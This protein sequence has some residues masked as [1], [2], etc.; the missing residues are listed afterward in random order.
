MMHQNGCDGKFGFDVMSSYPPAGQ[1]FAFRHA[2]D[3][4]VGSLPERFDR[5]FA[6]RAVAGDAAKAGQRR[7]GVQSLR[8]RHVELFEIHA[9]RERREVAFQL[10]APPDGPLIPRPGTFS[11]D[12]SAP[13][14]TRR[15]R[16]SREGSSGCCLARR[17]RE[18]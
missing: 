6:E 17:A 2:R 13:P 5:R 18:E 16:S 15:D 1:S 7:E 9:G 8:A 4:D 11:R 14:A 12:P 3:V 10:I